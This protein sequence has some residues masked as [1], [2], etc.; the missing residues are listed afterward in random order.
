M[1]NKKKTGGSKKRNHIPAAVKYGKDGRRGGSKK[2]VLNTS[3]QNLGDGTMRLNKFIAHAGVCSRREADEL[4]ALGAI[5][6]N[7]Q[8]I[9]EMGYK[10]KP[11]DVVKY[12]GDT[13][14]HGALYYFVINKPKNFSSA[15]ED[16]T[17]E[18]T[19]GRLMS[20]ACKMLLTPVGKL[21]REGTGV[22]LLSNDHDLCLKLSNPKHEFSKIYQ[23]ELDKPLAQE[24]LDKYVAGFRL[25]NGSYVKAEAIS[26]L[27]GNQHNIGIEILSNKNRILERVFEGMGYKIK[28]L[29]RVSFA[30]ITKKKLIRSEYRALTKEEVLSLKMLG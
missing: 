15:T 27:K 4:I 11:E 29:D 14:S 19:V 18:R 25:D 6:I 10:V 9:T 20:K 30:G 26:Y 22:L 1:A 7:G 3:E 5:T 28:K 21:E 16:P 8:I 24:D 23:L 2:K 12:E 17:K 13:L